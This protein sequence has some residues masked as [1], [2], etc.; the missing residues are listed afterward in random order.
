MVEFE[1]AHSTI[2]ALGYRAGIRSLVEVADESEDG[3]ALSNPHC[4]FDNSPGAMAECVRRSTLKS[5]TKGFQNENLSN[6]P[7]LPR[8]F[9]RS[10][11]LASPGID[12]LEQ[13]RI[14]IDF[15]EWLADAG[16]NQLSNHILLR[17][18]YRTSWHTS[19]GFRLG[20]H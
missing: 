9:H 17:A 4:P 2:K 11:E 18:F 15:S 14:N 16:S 10:H 19:A 5:Q 3:E 7:H 13:Q 6:L 8:V 12:Q 1:K 20:R